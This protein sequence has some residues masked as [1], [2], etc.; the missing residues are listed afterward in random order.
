MLFLQTV[1][2]GTLGVFFSSVASATPDFTP[3]SY[4]PIRAG[5]GGPV[6]LGWYGCWQVALEMRS[7][8]R[9]CRPLPHAS[10]G[11]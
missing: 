1:D 2:P 8:F 4:G 10:T 7:A 6:E 11:A 9:S 5:A 3:P